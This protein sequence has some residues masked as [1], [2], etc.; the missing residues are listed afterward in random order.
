[1]AESLERIESTLLQK[2]L[3]SEKEQRPT[4]KPLDEKLDA[5]SSEVQ[6]L[7]QEL[8]DLKSGTEK[9]EVCFFLFT[10]QNHE[11]IN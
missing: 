1:M 9:L 4:A 8:A 7:T 3:A 5:I 2:V 6:T 11:I 10:N